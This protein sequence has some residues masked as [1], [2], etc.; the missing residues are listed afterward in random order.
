MNPQKK[1]SDFISRYDFH[2]WP[3]LWPTFIHYSPNRDPTKLSF[4]WFSGFI[5][6]QGPMNAVMNIWIH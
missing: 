3:F 2:G 6:V 5:Q 1:N 4:H